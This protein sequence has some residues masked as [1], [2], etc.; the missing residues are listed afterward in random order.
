[1]AVVLRPYRLLAAVPHAST[2]MIASLLGR[3]HLPAIAMVMTFLIADWTGSYTAGGVL[4]AALTIGQ[5]IAG[6]VRGRAADRSSAPR[7]LLIT[8]GLYG[9]GLAVIA[10]VAR[11]GGLLDGSTWWSLLPVALL[12]GLAT[13]PVSQIGRGMWPRI[14]D[15]PAREAAY[16]VEATLQELLFVISPIL[17]ASAVAFWNPVVAMLLCAVMSMVGPAVFAGALWRAG[18]REAPTRSGNDGQAAGSLFRVPGFVPLLGFGALVVGALVSVDLVLVGWSRNRGTPELAG[19]LAA[20]WAIGSLAGGLLMGGVGGRPRVW[21]RG[22]MTGI[23]LVA[24]VPVLP[25]VADPA[26]PWLVAAVLLVGGTAVAP[27]LAAINGRLAE[28]APADR[29]SEAF[30]WFSTAST[31]GITVASPVAGWM[32]DHAGPAAAAAVGG[33]AALLAV[34][35]VARHSVRGSRVRGRTG[36]TATT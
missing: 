4:S 29:R 16:A 19:V 8:G 14:A 31:G 2:L 10:L 28:L 13:P 32:L 3:M 18:L 17:A 24:L 27:L 23:G 12:T 34:G 21:L 30:G 20:L 9:L 26:S 15:G 1:M 7:L 11:P 5:A 25:P 6:P 33:A 35:L 36:E 22:L